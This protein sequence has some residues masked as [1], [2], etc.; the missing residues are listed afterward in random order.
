MAEWMQLVFV[1]N[2]LGGCMPVMM[3][4]VPF[5]CLFTYWNV[6]YMILKFTIKPPA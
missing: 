2:I 6:K 3:I 4:L 1:C 5:S